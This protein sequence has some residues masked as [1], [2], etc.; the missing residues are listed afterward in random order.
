MQ[1]R[2]GHQAGYGGNETNQ[3]DQSALSVLLLTNK[4]IAI[5]DVWSVRCSV[6]TRSPAP[7]D[8]TLTEQFHTLQVCG[9]AC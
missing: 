3:S 7:K 8:I 6:T 2:C 5:L 9:T 4:M 1:I